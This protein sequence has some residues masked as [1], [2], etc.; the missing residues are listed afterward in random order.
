M[1]P[2]QLEHTRRRSSLRSSL[3]LDDGGEDDREIE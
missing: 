2:D 3:T 1:H